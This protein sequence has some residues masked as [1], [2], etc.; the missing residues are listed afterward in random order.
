MSSFKAFLE[1]LNDRPLADEEVTKALTQAANE[2]A[3]SVGL[4]AD[5]MRRVRMP[6]IAGP[7]TIHPKHRQLFDAREVTILE[8]GGETM[9]GFRI[10][11]RYILD[12]HLVDNAAFV[13][14][15]EAMAHMKKE[16][17]RGFEAGFD[18]QHDCL[19]SVSYGVFKVTPSKA[20]TK[21]G[22]GAR[23]EKRRERK[24]RGKR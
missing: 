6:Q 1:R 11:Q 19:R 9:S 8:G 14:T 4:L 2:S 7:I 17:W 15:D 5:A 13:I 16:L 24:R 23:R 18:W 10:E 22:Q 12:P 3:L 20:L 21:R